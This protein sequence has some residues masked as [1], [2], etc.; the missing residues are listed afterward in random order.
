QAAPPDRIHLLQRTL[1]KHG[2][3]IV[4]QVPDTLPYKYAKLMYNAAISPL[5]AI[6][7]LDNAALLT[8]PKARRLFF[9]FLKENYSILKQA[10]IPL[11]TIGP[12]HPDTVHRILRT[13]LL[14][15]CMSPVF[16]RTMRGTYC[17]MS[18][19]IERGQTEI[20]SFNGHLLTVAG[21]HPCPLNDRACALVHRMADEG[22][23][24]SIERLEDLNR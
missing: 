2:R 18:G 7:G 3:F 20:D 22:I 10:G 16:A 15:R 1:K 4:K 24:P 9:R 11:G 23:P 17:S 12:F 6:S 5:A 19:D 8:I 13:P 21:P 14:A